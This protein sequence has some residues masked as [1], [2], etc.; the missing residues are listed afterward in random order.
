MITTKKK[1]FNFL[2]KQPDQLTNDVIQRLGNT[3][4]CRRR[5]CFYS[6]FDTIGRAADPLKNYNKTSTVQE[7]WNY[8][9]EVYGKLPNHDNPFAIQLRSLFELAFNIKIAKF[10]PMLNKTLSFQ[11]STQ[12]VAAKLKQQINLYFFK[13]KNK[14]S[15]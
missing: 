1:D 9:A 11:L 4:G 12:H 8:L 14:L 7:K 2:S 5:Y 6:F 10:D 13:F 15:S 3:Y